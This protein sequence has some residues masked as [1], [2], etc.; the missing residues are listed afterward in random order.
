MAVAT[1][2]LRR[3]GSQEAQAAAKAKRQKLILI[4]GSVVLVAVLAFQLPK[5]LKSSSS[6]TSTATASSSTSPSTPGA[7][8]V[9]PAATGTAAPTISAAQAKHDLA[10]I[11][12]NYPT[13]DPFEVQISNGTTATSQPAPTIPKAPSV[14]RSHFVVKD[15]FKTQVSDG[16]TS[17]SSSAPTFATPP[18]VK[19]PKVH[20]TATAA[21]FGYIVIL[22]S[23]DSKAAALREVK[24]AHAQGLKSA[25]VL[26]SSKYTTLRHGY[27]VVYLNKYP[28]WNSANAGLQ[29][30]HAHGYASAYRRP[31]RK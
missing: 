30:A 18:P 25:G 5:L 27:W 11:A 20:K 22:R 23:L 1:S 15:P 4:V 29:T 8:T 31:V 28:T 21:P 16:T 19:T 12:R 2:T 24:A 26:Y 6:G 13:K 10:V 14:R 9:A 3:R 7:S 17:P